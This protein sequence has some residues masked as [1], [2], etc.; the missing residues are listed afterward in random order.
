[1]RCG[2]VCL[3]SGRY[4]L[5]RSAFEQEA[6]ERLKNEDIVLRRA[7]DVLLVP[8]ATDDTIEE[9]KEHATYLQTISDAQ[10]KGID[11]KYIA[12][13]LG[14]LCGTAIATIGSTWLERYLSKNKK[15]K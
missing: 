8:D 5:I 4:V 9:E 10:K 2:N 14:L 7:L 13:M 11:K 12:K 15:Y 6:N 3:T 1:M